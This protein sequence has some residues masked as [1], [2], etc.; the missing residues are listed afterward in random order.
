MATRGRSE[1]RKPKAHESGVKRNASWPDL[2]SSDTF[3]RV[4]AFCDRLRR[5]KLSEHNLGYLVA[6]DAAI[7]GLSH[8]EDLARRRAAAVALVSRALPRLTSVQRLD[9]LL[10]QLAQQVDP[11]FASIRVPRHGRYSAKRRRSTPGP[12]N[13]T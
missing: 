3:R 5:S 9:Q 11:R 1:A 8:P 13:L 4:I 10:R 7:R 12:E 2:E 6:A